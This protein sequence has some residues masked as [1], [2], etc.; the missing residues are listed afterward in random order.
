MPEYLRDY[1]RNKIF[2]FQEER[3]LQKLHQI[4]KDP[5]ERSHFMNM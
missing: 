2:N 3:D 4:S 5:F 1:S